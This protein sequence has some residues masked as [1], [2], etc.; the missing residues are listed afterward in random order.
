M[1][2]HPL[3][4]RRSARQLHDRLRTGDPDVLRGIVDDYRPLLLA[5]LTPTLGNRADAENVLQQCVIE[6][7]RNSH[8]FDPNRGS[9]RTWLLTICRSRAFD[10]LRRRVPEPRDPAVL[11]AE[12]GRERAAMATIVEG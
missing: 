8:K 7:W 12:H 10:H 5:Y 2:R 4:S 3:R 11:S 1:T 9:V 6:V